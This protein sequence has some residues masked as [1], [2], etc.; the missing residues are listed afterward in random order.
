MIYNICVHSV[1]LSSYC[2]RDTSPKEDQTPKKN[3]VKIL[4]NETK[5]NKTKFEQTQKYV[6]KFNKFRQKNECMS[7]PVYAHEC[8]CLPVSLYSSLF[9]IMNRSKLS[10]CAT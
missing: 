10:Y 5:R 9:F 4:T 7:F 6:A 3:K 1:L 2:V 8:S